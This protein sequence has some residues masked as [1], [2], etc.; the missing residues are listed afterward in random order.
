MSG[1]AAEFSGARLCMNDAMAMVVCV[2][3]ICSKTCNKSKIM[4]GD[5]HKI[6]TITI[7]IVI[8]T[9]LT[10]ALGI[11]PR[12]LARL[13]ASSAWAPFRGRS[14]NKNEK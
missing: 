7:T 11:S 12:E 9:V 3:G 8:L 14:A 6:N 2:R 1:L 10:L 13:L 4:Y 5:Q